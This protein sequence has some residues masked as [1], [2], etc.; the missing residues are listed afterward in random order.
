MST[1]DSTGE[2]DGTGEWEEPEPEEPCP[3]IPPYSISLS[4]CAVVCTCGEI[5]SDLNPQMPE[6][7]RVKR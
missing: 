2:L 5:M 3:H 6:V 1:Y 7:M 4:R